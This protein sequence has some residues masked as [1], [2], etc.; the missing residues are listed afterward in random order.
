[1]TGEQEERSR[2][3]GEGNSEREKNELVLQL[4]TETQ[5]IHD[6]AEVLLAAVTEEPGM[7]LWHLAWQHTQRISHAHLTAP[8]A[9]LLSEVTEI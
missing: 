2:R 6:Q 3:K 1:M 5:K 8:F 7:S 4:Q 9:N